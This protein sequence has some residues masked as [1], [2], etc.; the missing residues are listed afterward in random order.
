MEVRRVD[1]IKKL[2]FGTYCSSSLVGQ[3][4]EVGNPQIFEAMC[5]FRCFLR[6]TLRARPGNF[7]HVMTRD[8]FRGEIVFRNDRGYIYARD[9]N[10]I[11]V[12][13]G[14]DMKRIKSEESGSRLKHPGHR[15]WALHTGITR[16]TFNET[17]SNEQM[18]R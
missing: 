15:T 13:N 6:V 2:G 8:G 1:E 9:S 14:G 18:N 16:M 10:M 12:N 7:N 11:R 17:L 4:V 5:S 3:K